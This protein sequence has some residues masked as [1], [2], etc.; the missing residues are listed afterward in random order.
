MSHRYQWLRDGAAVQGA[1]SSTYR[2]APSDQGRRMSVRVTAEKSGHQPGTA[3]STTTA[4]VAS[5]TSRVSIRPSRTSVKARQKLKVGVTVTAPSLKPPGKV[6]V[7][8]RGKKVRSLRLKNGKVSATFRPSVKGRFTLKV[9][10]RGAK[11]VKSS[12]SSV[13]IRVR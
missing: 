6:D 5:A 8:Y 12:T 4:R 7:Y 1:T 11:G 10:Y 13:K 3:T 2:L 9:V